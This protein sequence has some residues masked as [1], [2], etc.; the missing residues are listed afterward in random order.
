MSHQAA[1]HRAQS[2][3]KDLEEEMAVLKKRSAALSQLAVSEDYVLFLKEW[4]GVSVSSEL[5]SGVIL[6]AVNSMTECLQ[7]EM[8]KLSEI[9]QRPSLDQSVPRPNPKTGG[10]K[11][12]QPTSLWTTTLPTHVSSSQ[13]MQSRC[14][15]ETATAVTRQPERFDR[16]VCVLGHQGFNQDDITGR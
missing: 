4:S 3:L 5:T 15:A 11:N 14:T 8:R 12:M 16:V 1:A 6:R 9:C 7:E 10:F 2:L 13:Q